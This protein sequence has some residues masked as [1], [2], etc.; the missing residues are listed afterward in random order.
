MRHNRLAMCNPFDED[1]SVD[2]IHRRLKSDGVEVGERKDMHGAWAFYVT[3]PGGFVVEVS[4]QR[5]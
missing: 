3:A 1:A 2:E 4:H 5:E